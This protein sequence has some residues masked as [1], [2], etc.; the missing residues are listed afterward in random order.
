ML[1]VAMPWAVLGD[2]SRRDVERLP[3]FGVAATR[4]LEIEAARALPPHTL[5]QRAGGSVA[6]LALA[7][8]PHARRIWIA[9]GPGNNGGD[10]LEAA[11]WLQRA[12]KQVTVSLAPSVQTPADAAA[13]GAKARAAGVALVESSAP[14]EP[15]GPDNLAI[16]ALFGIGLTRA[17]A[18]WALA[19]MRSL[20]DGGTPVS[21]LWLHGRRV[22]YRAP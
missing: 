6:R 8:A 5:M 19:A 15:L 7:L 22:A 3:L 17:P 21:A 10:G 1:D 13:A 11:A 20:N 12:G 9:A 14:P 16:D 2:G 4:A 18:G